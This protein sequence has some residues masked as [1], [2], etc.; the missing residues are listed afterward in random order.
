M[1]N[2]QPWAQAQVQKDAQ[3]D[4]PGVFDYILALFVGVVAVALLAVWNFPIPHPSAWTDMSVAAGLRP[5]EHMFPN[6]GRILTALVFSIFPLRSDASMVA[7]SWTAHLF[8]GVTVALAYMLFSDILRLLMRGVRDNP[9]WR[10]RALRL[11]VVTATLLFAFSD[12]I[13]RAGQTFTADTVLILLTVALLA[14]FFRFICTGRLGFFYACIFITGMMCA[15]SPAGVILSI[16]VLIGSFVAIRR[17]TDIS[18]PFYNPLVMQFSK[19]R[20]SFFLIVGLIAA[21]SINVVSFFLMGGMEAS[22][23]D[24]ANLIIKSVIH[25]GIVTADAASIVG[26]LLMIVFAVVP[27]VVSVVLFRGATDEDNFLPYRSGIVYMLIGVVAF[28]QFSVIKALWFWTWSTENEIMPSLYLRCLCILMCAIA[29]M[30]SLTVL[31]VTFYLRNNHRIMRQRFPELLDS[32][33]ETARIASHRRSVRFTRRF[34]GIV[35]AVLLV[36]CVLPSRRQEALRDMMSALDEY[37][38]ETVKEAAD[39]RWLFT[40]GHFDQAIELQSAKQGGDLKALSM[41]SEHTNFDNALR[42]RGVSAETEEENRSVLENGSVDALRTWICDREPGAVKFAVQV[43]YEFW[44]RGKLVIPPVGGVLVRPG[45]SK[46]EATAG[47]ESARRLADRILEMRKPEVAGRFFDLKVDR[48]ADVVLWRVSRMS[49][50]KAEENDRAGQ[51]QNAA[52]DI[53]FSD[54]LDKANVSLVNLLETIQRKA[55]ESGPQLTPREGLRLALNR[56]DFALASRYA[57]PILNGDPDDAEANFGTGMNFLI[58]KQYA[59]AEEHLKRVLVNRPK[60][61]AALNN[62]AVCLMYLNRFDEAETNANKA[63]TIMPNSAEVRETLTLISKARKEAEKASS[64]L[65][66]PSQ[67]LPVKEEHKE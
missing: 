5:P 3:T 33:F 65:K 34:G 62:L 35:F 21:I 12:P 14:L 27:L 29:G 18:L 26:W 41:M 16:F 50:L 11:I 58:D 28:T 52:A 54:R 7:L 20:M 42:V 2:A 31:G 38:N 22:G 57:I 45:M 17:L 40:D 8:I 48:L 30:L 19:W 46:E 9:I 43:G 47:I 36:A 1:T 64:V 51:P 44:K 37:V 59:R 23:W 67:N 6:F 60:E 24:A 10:N 56:A 39:S 53:E 55:R 66:N 25:Y 4:G 63:L 61:V 13:W 15:E 49:R 32:Q